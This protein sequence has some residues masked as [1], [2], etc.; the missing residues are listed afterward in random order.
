MSCVLEI[1][2]IQWQCGASI[3]VVCK[4]EHPTLPDLMEHTHKD[5]TDCHAHPPL[6]VH[7]ADL[8]QL[9]H[10]LNNEPPPGL[11]NELMDVSHKSG[12]N[13]ATPDITNVL[14]AA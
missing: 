2:T 13:V 3:S 10:E 14:A 8:S 9:L 7:A 1:L 11:N 12:N 6:V 5:S 4:L